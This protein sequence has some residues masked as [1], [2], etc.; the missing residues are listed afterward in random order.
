MTAIE[1]YGNSITED[2][3]ENIVNAFNVL[4]IVEEPLSSYP[5]RGDIVI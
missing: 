4:P 1:Y 2:F 5:I 3:K